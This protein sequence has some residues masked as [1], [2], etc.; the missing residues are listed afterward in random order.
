MGWGVC[1][2]WGKGVGCVCVGK[3][4]VGVGLGWGYGGGGERVVGVGVGLGGRGCRPVGYV[5][6]KAC[7]RLGSAKCKETSAH[8]LTSGKGEDKQQV[9]GV[10]VGGVGE[11]S[12]GDEGMSVPVRPQ[13]G[14]LAAVQGEGKEGKWEARQ[15]VPLIV[16]KDKTLSG[17]TTTA[18]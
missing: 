16:P 9:N 10:G 4:W 15:E 12:L 13:S 7:V 3:P 17:F 14:P 6:Q 18:N 2:V 11:C 8:S 5:R 1:G